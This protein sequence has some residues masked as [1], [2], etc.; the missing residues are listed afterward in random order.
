MTVRMM[1]ICRLLRQ[2][3]SEFLSPTYRHSIVL[4]AEK[5]TAYPKVQ[6]CNHSNGGCKENTLFAK[7]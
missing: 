1:V 5:G 7:I 2:C 6:V 3:M 4:L